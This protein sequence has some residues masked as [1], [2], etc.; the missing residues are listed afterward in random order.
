MDPRKGY[1]VP[2]E[3]VRMPR[4]EL[5]TTLVDRLYPGLKFS[6]FKEYA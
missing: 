2:R 4:T 1:T 5:S 3:S 6:V